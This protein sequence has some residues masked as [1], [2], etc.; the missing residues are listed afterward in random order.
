MNKKIIAIIIELIPIISA[1]ISYILVI[2]PNNSKMAKLTILIAFFGFLFFFIGRKL[3]K[4]S[5][6]VKVLG[7]LDLLA[8]LYV[9]LLYTIVIFVFGL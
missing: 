2:S 6:L 8:T 4:D 5:R 3:N 1:P 9:I 7:I